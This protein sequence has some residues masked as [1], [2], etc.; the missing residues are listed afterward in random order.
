MGM[1][2]D[3]FTQ[4]LEQIGDPDTPLRLPRLHGLS[5]L[6]GERLDRFCAALNAY[7]TERRRRLLRALLRLAEGSFELSF[8]AI[9]RH[10]LQDTDPIVRATAV[11]GLWEDRNPRLIDPLL[12]M[13]R[14]DPSPRV[15]AAVAAGLG[16][17]VLAGELEQLET[18][19]EARVLSELLTVAYLKGESLDVRR[20]AVESAA[21]SGAPEVADALK[22]AYVHD[23]ERMRLSAVLGMGRSC[24][25]RWRPTLL[26]ELRSDS[27]AMRYEAVLACGELGLRESAPVLGEL[28]HDPNP[29]VMQATIWALGQIGGSASRQ[30][31][32]DAYEGADDDTQVAL[33]EALAEQTLSSDDSGFMLDEMN[34]VEG[35]A[36]LEDGEEYLWDNQGQDDMDDAGLDD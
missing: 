16:R 25:P 10:S 6:H 31:L 22:R 1:K 34:N 35:E 9:F 33:D 29:Q 11:E 21:Y 7:P 3:D 23:D 8:D 27:P 15:R 18:P 36:W 5:D 12:A 4:L 13:L 32:L 26:K 19:L 28:L 30:L 14:S 17:F 24:D 20:R 2:V